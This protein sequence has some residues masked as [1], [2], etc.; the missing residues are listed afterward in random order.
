MSD[1]G[2]KCNRRGRTIK[3]PKKYCTT[4][5]DKP[6]SKKKAKSK[7][8]EEM[9]AMF[10][11]SNSE[12]STDTPS[13]LSDNESNF[14]TESENNVE[15]KKGS[16]KN[17]QSVRKEKGNQ[18]KP[19]A[20]PDQKKEGNQEKTL[21]PTSEQQLEHHGN[22][23]LNSPGYSTQTLQN[24]Y[25]QGD[26]VMRPALDNTH[27]HPQFYNSHNNNYGHISCENSENANLNN[28]RASQERFFQ[29]FE[30]KMHMFCETQEQYVSKKIDDM[31]N[32]YEKKMDELKTYFN[33]KLDN[34]QVNK[35]A[36][37]NGGAHPVYSLPE[38]FPLK[39]MQKFEEFEK[40]EQKQGE[41][42]NYFI[43]W[44]NPNT[45][46][47]LRQYLRYSISDE[48]ASHFKWAQKSNK[49]SNE[50]SENEE[51]EPASH[52]T[53]YDTQLSKMMF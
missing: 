42:R 10:S 21:K 5:S 4:D 36:N 8:L 14:S 43:W 13:Q 6:T 51:N 49:E 29:K 16:E 27:G 33:T 39:N 50:E 38:G 40:N 18:D 1:K 17:E 11:N 45:K 28:L 7:I 24:N 23:N 41:L 47:A 44:G 26:D 20:K 48:L 12:E 46:I 9:T 2:S 34:L 19:A 52:R 35:N 3:K 25:D 22:N 30:E 15:M 32:Y 53:L 37:N 31:Q